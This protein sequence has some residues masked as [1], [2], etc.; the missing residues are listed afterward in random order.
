MLHCCLS[1]SGSH[2][3]KDFFE[4]LLFA[5]AMHFHFISI[6]FRL[7]WVQKLFKI[8]FPVWHI[9]QS[10]SNFWFL[11]MLSVKF[12]KPQ[13]KFEM[14]LIQLLIS[15]GG[16]PIEIKTKISE[17]ITLYYKNSEAICNK[18]AYFGFNYYRKSTY[19]HN[20][21]LVAWIAVA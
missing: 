8:S 15:I 12:F 9:L 10:T 5:N 19:R 20:V 6:F 21:W 18:L 11:E 3:I 14:Y 1:Q 13:M 2:T 4:F 16:F 17:L 7:Y